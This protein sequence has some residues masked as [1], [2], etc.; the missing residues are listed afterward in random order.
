MKPRAFFLIA[1]AGIPA[2]HD[3]DRI[4][5]AAGYSTLAAYDS[6]PAE[7]ILTLRFDQ[8]IIMTP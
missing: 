7:S 6:I 2:D 5:L 8:P 4:M 1:G 3:F